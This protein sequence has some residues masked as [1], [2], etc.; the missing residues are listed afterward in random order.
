MWTPAIAGIATSLMVRRRVD[1][2]GFRLGAARYF[3]F[4]YAIPLLF[5]VPVYLLTWMLHLGAFAPRFPFRLPPGVSG[6]VILLF[7]AL[8]IAPLGM[9]DTLGE[10][11]G[12][13]GMLT[14]RLAEVTTFTR[15]SLIRGAIWSLWH[16]PLV[17]VLLP[18][19]R[20]GLPL[21][22]ALVCMT[23]AT[24]AISFVY[25][26]L[27]LR[28]GSLWPCALLHAVSSNCQ[29]VF[30]SGTRDTGHTHYITYEYGAGFAIM[31]TLLAVFVWRKNA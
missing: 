10:E 4:S 31:L 11:I 5:C 6:F 20:A 23:I 25:T 12:W 21:W 3:G 15:A 1:G 8:L 16:Y 7:L 17:I 24:V 22:Y 19:Y 27:R 30:E 14:P 26:W 28:S 13:S 9:I 29:D 18:Q 2:F